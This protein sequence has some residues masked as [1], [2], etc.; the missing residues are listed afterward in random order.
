MITVSATACGTGW[1]H[2]AA[3]VQTLQ[4][5]N[6]L[7]GAVEVALVDADNG[8]VYARLE[9]LGP[10]T[11]RAMPVDVGSGVYAFDCSGTT[12]GDR[13]RSVPSGSRDTFEAALGSSR[14]AQ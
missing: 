12:Y 13:T 14:S 11:T 6:A 10:G 2:P 7:A 8:A 4:I 5:H 3:G 9:G 1:R